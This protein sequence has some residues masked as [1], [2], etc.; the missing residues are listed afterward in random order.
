MGIKLGLPGVEIIDQFQFETYQASNAKIIEIQSRHDPPQSQPK[1]A[2]QLEQHNTNNYQLKPFMNEKSNSSTN[3]A[4]VSLQVS[5]SR[6]ETIASSLSLS[7]TEAINT[8][9]DW[10][11][12]G[13]SIAKS[14]EIEDPTPETLMIR[15]KELEQ[16]SHLKDRSIPIAPN[17]ASNN[18]SVSVEE[19]QRLLFTIS[20]LSS[21][22]EFLSQLLATNA[23]SLRETTDNPNSST[24]HR[25]YTQTPYST[26]RIPRSTPEPKKEPSEIR[27]TRK[28]S[29]EKRERDTTEVMIA[30]INRAIDAIIEFNNTPNRPHKQKFRVSV[31]PVADLAERST[32]SVSKV[33]EERSEEIDS[34]HN[35]HQLGEY[36]NRGRKD[37]DGNKYPPITQEPEIN[38]TKLTDIT[39]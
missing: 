6:L 33:I 26:G 13:V 22:V 29:S 9:V 5:L 24:N 3:E 11:E 10:A 12:A 2:S 37:D 39:V 36:H 15:V 30:D 32:N 38:Y 18:N 1:L 19:H 17:S 31:K 7:H 34:H 25:P 8:L 28:V 21:S 27:N 23:R 35:Q 20:S 16:T 14:L 4:V